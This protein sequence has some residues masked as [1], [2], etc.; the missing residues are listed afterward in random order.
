MEQ[1][2]SLYDSCMKIESPEIEHFTGCSLCNSSLRLAEDGFL[3]CSNRACSVPCHETRQN[4]DVQNWRCVLYNFHQRL[5]KKK[6]T[7]GDRLIYVGYQIRI[8]VIKFVI[9]INQMRTTVHVK[10]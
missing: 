6:Y 2:W 7:F 3:I 10:N 8:L 4:L 5:K 1:A 9:K